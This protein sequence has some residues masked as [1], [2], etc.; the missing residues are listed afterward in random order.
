MRER[1]RKKPLGRSRRKLEGNMKMYLEE[2]VYNDVDLIQLPRVTIKR[3]A[4]VSKV[5]NLRVP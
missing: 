2:L 3:R 4:L 1:E 5:V